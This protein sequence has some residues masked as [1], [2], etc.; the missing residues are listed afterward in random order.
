MGYFS[1]GTE[2]MDYHAT[3]CAHCKHDENEDCPV[4]AAHLAFNYDECNKPESILHMLIPRSKDKLS[5]EECKMFMPKAPG[6]CI[7]TR[8]MFA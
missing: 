4:W 3:Y 6:R 8:D 7:K 1:N 5:N 2:G